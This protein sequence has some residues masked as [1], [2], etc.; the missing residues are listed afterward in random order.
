MHKCIKLNNGQPTKPNKG[1]VA[2]ASKSCDYNETVIAKVTITKCNSVVNSQANVPAPTNKSVASES[3]AKTPAAGPSVSSR[4]IDTTAR[5]T[6][7]DG[8]IQQFN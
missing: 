7:T 4:I 1:A 6:T 5:M 2:P 8:K 3:V